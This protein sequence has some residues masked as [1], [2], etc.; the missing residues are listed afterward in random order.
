MK[1]V[2]YGSATE[3][4]HIPAMRDVRPENFDSAISRHTAL[5]MLRGVKQSV[6]V[7]SVTNNCYEL[8]YTRISLKEASG[9]SW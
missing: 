9:R 3:L 6:P 7:F 1:T 5:S 4:E 2:C 8:V